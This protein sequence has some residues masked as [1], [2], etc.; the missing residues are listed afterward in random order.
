MTNAKTMT[1]H[2]NLRRVRNHRLSY[3]RIFIVC[4]LFL[5]CSNDSIYDQYQTIGQTSWEKN[6][7]YYF[8]FMV[9]DISVPYDVA[10]SVRNNNRYPYQN[11]WIFCNEEQP[12]GP[13]KKDTIECLLADEYGKWFGHGISLFQSSYIIHSHYLFPHTGQYTISIQQGMRDENLRGIQE[14]GLRVA[15]S[16]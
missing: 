14:I 7:E 1:N 8:T 3:L 11:L 15:R 2:N 9:D 12:I 5:S 6:K 13:L 4:C 16:R 10:L